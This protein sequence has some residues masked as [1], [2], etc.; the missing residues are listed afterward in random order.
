MSVYGGGVGQTRNAQ[1]TCI[2]VLDQKGRDAGRTQTHANA[3]TARTRARVHTHGLRHF[4]TCAILVCAFRVHVLPCTFIHR[5]QGVAMPASHLPT[6]CV[7]YPAAAILVA[8]PV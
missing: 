5:I 1:A 3:R 6:K 2:V 7:R 8:M 4:E